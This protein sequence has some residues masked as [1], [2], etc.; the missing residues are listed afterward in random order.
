MLLQQLSVIVYH[1]VLN[2]VSTAH[3]NRDS[4]CLY[5]SVLQYASRNL[6]AMLMTLTLT[7]LLPT[8]LLSLLTPLPLL[9]LLL[10]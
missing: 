2:G 5:S 1:T 7:L 9:P 6:V 4:K 3:A 8:L 10:L